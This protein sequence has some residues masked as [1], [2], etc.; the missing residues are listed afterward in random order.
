MGADIG[1]HLVE[2]LGGW[3]QIPSPPP[4]IERLNRFSPVQRGILIR[5]LQERVKQRKTNAAKT[6][7]RNA[8]DS[9]H[10]YIPPVSPRQFFLDN[11]YMGHRGRNLHPLLLDRLCR[12]LNN[13]FIKQVILTGAIGWGKNYAAHMGISYELYHTLCRKNP[14]SIFDNAP[15]SRIVFATLSVDGRSAHDVMWNYVTDALMASPLFQNHEL[16]RPTGKDMLWWPKQ[17]VVWMAGNSRE[18]SILGENVI[19]GCLDELNFMVGAAQSRHSK[20]AGEY[21]Q[22]KVLFD[23]FAGR[24]A[25]RYVT[26]EDFVLARL[27]MIS[28]KQFPGDFLERRIETSKG[29][30][31]VAVLDYPQW[32]PKMSRPDHKYGTKRFYIFLG[33]AANP[34]RMLG[35]DDQVEKADL[36]KL[37]DRMP[38]GCRIQAVPH[39]LKDLYIDN[40]HKA[41]KDISGWSILARNPFMEETSIYRGCVGLEDCGDIPREHPFKLPEPQGISASQ[42][43]R[44]K[45]PTQLL[46]SK[47]ELFDPT[48]YDHHKTAENFAKY[49]KVNPHR[50]RYVHGDLARTK[51]GAAFAIGHF[52]GYK[53]RIVKEENEEVEGGWIFFVEERPITI[54]DVMCRFY[55]PPGGKLEPR[56]LRDIIWA[57]YAFGEY[58]GFERVSFDQFQSADSIDA[59]EAVGIEAELLS[60]E[61]TT[62]PYEYLRQSMIDR[63]TSFYAYE[64][65]FMDCSSLEYDTELDK[66]NCTATRADGTLGTKDVADC[67]AAVHAHIARDFHVIRKP[68]PFTLGEMEKLDIANS[69]ER[70]LLKIMGGSAPENVNTDPFADFNFNL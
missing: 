19:G 4:I 33:N 3:E 10:F 25:S 6:P 24:Q 13:P 20:L 2:G 47:G 46:N 42:I 43:L 31:R 27:Y 67:V 37:A 55:A 29:N 18:S 69:A 54:I 36:K 11:D 26:E 21:D 68:V 22:A 50:T 51:C 56:R 14:Q 49:P 53:Q 35:D 48:R 40:L 34:S 65:F 64:P 12:I 63:R 52:G 30:P 38:A 70:Q 45:F 5:E 16:F 62:A 57:C 15:D 58:P 32:L 60:L 8:L 61:R 23:A 66:I 59:F 7:T 44:S 28:S 9:E 39:K 17:N 1:Q 41:I